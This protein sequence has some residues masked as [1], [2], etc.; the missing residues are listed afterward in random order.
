MERCSP[1]SLT[2]DR[3]A[4]VKTSESDAVANAASCIAPN[5][6]EGCAMYKY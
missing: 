6:R 2:N 4:E 5:E 1:E 3:D